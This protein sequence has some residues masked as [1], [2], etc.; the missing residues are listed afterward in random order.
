MD[1][2]LASQIVTAAAMLAGCRLQVV[3][4]TPTTSSSST[5]SVTASIRATGA[6]I[7]IGH[8]DTRRRARR[9]PRTL[10]TR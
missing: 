1:A 5:S 4:Q 7:G 9:F 6:N 10:L 2:A 8:S 3:G